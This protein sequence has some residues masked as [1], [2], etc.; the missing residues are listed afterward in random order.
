[1]RK[2]ITAVVLLVM[3]M[4]LMLSG[5]SFISGK[6]VKSLSGRYVNQLN[7]DDYFVFSKGGK[8][9][10]NHNGEK[11]NGTYRISEGVVYGVIVTNGA[12]INVG[13]DYP[14]GYLE[15]TA[16]MDDSTQSDNGTL[17]LLQIENKKTLGIG[18]LIYSRSTW[19]SRNWWKILIG[20]VIFGIII[21]IY[22]KATGKD[23][24]EEC[25]KVGD[26]MDKLFDGDDDS[27]S[28]DYKDKKD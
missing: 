18:A 10:Y 21:T 25:E 16:N 17:L 2:R 23:F 22:E 20:L 14:D 7:N 4:V 11:F 26:K 8:V 15:Y 9:E 1:M 24:E 3:A 5:C 27:D 13:G 19:L 6:Y 12:E 28:S